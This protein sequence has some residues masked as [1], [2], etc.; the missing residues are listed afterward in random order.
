MI[1][2]LVDADFIPN[3]DL[4]PLHQ[5]SVTSVTYVTGRYLHY[6]RDL[7]QAL[8][9]ADFIPNADLYNQLVLHVNELQVL[10]FPALLPLRTLRAGAYI[11]CVTC[12]YQ[13]PG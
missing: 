1:Q 9:D 3:A 13:T 8:V 4:Y 12:V 2:A 6:V 10:T 5:P 11:T 7:I